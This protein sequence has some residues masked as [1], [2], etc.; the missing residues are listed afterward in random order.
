MPNWKE[1]LEEIQSEQTK[2]TP[3]PL[4][5]V[6]RKYLSLIEKKTGRNT[7]AYYSGW[8]QKPQSPDTI[9]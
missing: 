1:V 2:G 4:D 3:N 5:S 6:R 8:L 7:I 9:G